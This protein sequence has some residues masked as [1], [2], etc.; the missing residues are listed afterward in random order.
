MRKKI[1][2]IVSSIIT[3]L[4]LLLIVTLSIIGA[5]KSNGANT[6]LYTIISGWISGIATLIIGILTLWLTNKIDMVS[7]AKDEQREKELN[8]QYQNQLKM[9]ANPTI[10][11]NNIKSF[12]F[13]N[14]PI[15]ISNNEFVNRL[16]D[17]KVENKVVSASGYISFELVFNTPKPENVEN[18]FIKNI[19]FIVKNEDGFKDGIRQVFENYTINKNANL[20]YNNSG[21]LECHT[22][23]LILEEDKIEK[24]F[25]V[26]N[27]AVSTNQNV[28]LI[29]H[30][31]ASNSLGVH[32]DY[33]CG[34]YFKLLDKKDLE[35]EDYKYSIQMIDNFMWAEEVYFL[36]DKEL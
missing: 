26:I 2:K 34:F 12:H 35:F 3:I 4:L 9:T 1:F 25:T 19:E 16:L 22:D 30:L 11:F 29:T 13:A 36:K 31:T 7:K 10:Y 21:C 6:N 14:H 18:I 28:V 15:I 17:K 27:Q 33:R 5:Y 8:E 24:L 32:K 23:L 20:K